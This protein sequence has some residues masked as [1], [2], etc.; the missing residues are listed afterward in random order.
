[1]FTKTCRGK[2]VKEKLKSVKT[3][4]S[5]FILYSS[6]CES[7]AFSPRELSFDCAKAYVWSHET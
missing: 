3:D 7:L 5:L 2:V 4:F 1:M 6:F